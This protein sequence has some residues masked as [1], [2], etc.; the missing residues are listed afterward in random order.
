MCVSTSPRLRPACCCARAPWSWHDVG[1]PPPLLAPQGHAGPDNA[2]TYNN[3]PSQTGFFGS[4]TNNYAS[5]YGQ[6]FLGWYSNALI[7]HGQRVMSAAASVFGSLPIAA[8]VAGVHW[9]V[10]PHPS[11]AV[12]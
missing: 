3:I 6:F 8:K 2:G 7:S 4:G 9:C 12:W 11:P 1:L 10:A 5:S